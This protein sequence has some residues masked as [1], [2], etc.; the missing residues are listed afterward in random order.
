MR[1]YES[2]GDCIW[3]TVPHLRVRIELFMGSRPHFE[4][5]QVVSMGGLVIK[6]AK[7]DCPPMISLLSSSLCEDAK[8]H[9]TATGRFCSRNRRGQYANPGSNAPTMITSRSSGGSLGVRQSL[10][11]TTSYPCWHPVGQAPNTV[12]AQRLWKASL[13]SGSILRN[14]SLR[15]PG[16][17]TTRSRQLGS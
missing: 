5:S 2:Q 8:A 6:L 11:Q 7:C 14:G 3:R 16:Q 17:S 15:T 4:R 1:E 12:F 10:P 9:P 13:V